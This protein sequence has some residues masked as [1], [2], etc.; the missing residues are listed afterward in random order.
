MAQMIPAIFPFPDDP[1]RKAEEK[2][3]GI[4]RDKLSDEYIVFYSCEVLRENRAGTFAESETDFLIFHPDQG[5][6]GIEVKGG[7]IGYKNGT[8]SQNGRPLKRSPFVQAHDA[9][10]NLQRW[11]AWKMNNLPKLTFAHGVC[12]PD[13]MK[14]F[15]SLPPDAE[16]TI[17]LT[18]QELS[19]VADA[20]ESI[21]KK[22]RRSHHEKAPRDAVRRLLMPQFEYGYCLA[23][24][25]ERAEEDF[26]TLTEQQCEMLNMLQYQKRALIEGCA[27]SGKTIMALK[28]AEEIASMD[29]SVLLLC[30]NT[31][32]G[33][34]LAARTSN[35]DRITANLFHDFCLDALRDAG[36]AP[37]KGSD[38]QEY[39]DKRVPEAFDEL[40]QRAALEYDAVIVDEG[41]DFRFS[42]WVSIEG[43]AKKDGWFYIF[44]DP[45]QNLFHSD[46]EFP[47]K[48]PRFALTKNCRNTGRICEFLQPLSTVP[49][50]PKDGIPPGDAPVEFSDP[51]PKNRRKE[52]GK[53][54]N[55]LVT[56]E[57]LDRSEVVVLG[58]HR[59]DGTSIGDDPKIGNFTLTE[60]ADDDTPNAIHYHTHMKFKGLEARA[61]ILLDVDPDDERWKM[62]FLYTAA[63]RAKY[64]LH[65]LRKSASG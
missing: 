20:V 12:F 17:C 23:D 30:Y 60:N 65:V 39:W 37:E 19:Y 35:N 63:S 57:K 47:F 3:F 64:V 55:R 46:M 49:M 42:Y 15:D 43:L 21:L 48:K 1:L 10:H 13:V 51:N 36:C 53:V 62:N 26:F 5:F 31:L 4:F 56:Q 59:M 11:L 34:Q 25:A 27:G 45:G 8:W 50:E 2:V 16:R 38:D 33:K 24:R 22:F 6:L 54:L 9:V 14:A 40:M 44:Y 29:K 61:I 58:G 41:Q 18:H 52:L 7:S 28:K 32:L